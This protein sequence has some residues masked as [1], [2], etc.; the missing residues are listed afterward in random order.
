MIN[1]LQ[2]IPGYGKAGVTLKKAQSCN[3]SDNYATMLN[4]TIKTI[5]KKQYLDGIFRLKL[6]FDNNIRVKPS[7]PFLLYFYNNFASF[8]VQSRS[9]NDYWKTFS[10]F[11]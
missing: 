1:I 11:I 6:A 3:F 5:D 2:I 9:K 10:T 8:A 4:T 7:L